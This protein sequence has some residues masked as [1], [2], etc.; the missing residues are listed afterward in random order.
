MNWV[1]TEWMERAACQ[2]LDTKLFFVERGG[3]T[4]IAR[5]TCIRCPVA[6]ECRDYAVE[7]NIDYGIWGNTVP[8][9]RRARRRDLAETR[10]LHRGG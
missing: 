7:N 2:G 5:G 6:K 3:S 4:R 1:N 8:R 10:N 9:Q